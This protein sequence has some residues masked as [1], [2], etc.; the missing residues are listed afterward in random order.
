MITTDTLVQ[1][2][3]ALRYVRSRMDRRTFFESSTWRPKTAD[4]RPP[5]STTQWTLFE[6]DLSDWLMRCDRRR[7]ARLTT[8]SSRRWTHDPQCRTPALHLRQARP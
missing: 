6:R 4:P 5:T 1:T 3:E 7:I 8:G 2:I